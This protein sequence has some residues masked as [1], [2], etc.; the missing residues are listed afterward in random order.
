MLGSLVGQAPPTVCT[1]LCEPLLP[2]ASRVL[3]FAGNADI[4]FVGRSPES[5]FDLISGVLFETSWLERLKLLHF[6]MRWTELAKVGAEHPQSIPALRQY[7]T[8]LGLEPARISRHPR[9]VALIDWVQTGGTFEI[10]RAH[11]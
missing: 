5:L 8:V 10:G 2:C 6:S 11:V 4:V 3:A 1:E 7:L 9:P